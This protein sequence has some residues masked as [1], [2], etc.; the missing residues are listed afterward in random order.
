MIKT[1]NIN[2]AG[3]IF[4][5]NEDAYEQLLSY[6][7]SLEKFYVNEEGK[8]EILNDIKARF[9][10]LF[11]AKGKNIIISMEDAN[12][13]INN[14]G[15]PEEFDVSEDST[16]TTAEQNTTTQTEFASTSTSKRLF[17]DNDNAL[18]AGVCSGLSYYFGIND[19]VWL[20]LAFIIFV[21]IGFGSPF[22]IYLILW[23]ILPEATTSA[24]KLEMKG[25]KI[26]L[27]NIEKKV[28]DEFNKVSD[29]VSKN[30][31]GVLSK[32]VNFIGKFVLLF[33][34]FILGLGAVLAALIGGATVL[35]LFIGALVIAFISIFGIPLAN[36]FFFE[37]SSDGWM[38]GIGILLICI[39]PVI[40]GVVTLIHVLSKKTK[41]L[42]KQLVFPLIGLFLFGFLLINI[43][44]YHAKQ[45]IAE[46]RKIN[47][48]FSIQN[49]DNLDT[50]QLTIN[51][52][53]LD[54]EHSGDNIEINGISD[55]IE[56][57][58]DHNENIYP[59]EIEIYPSI[60]DSFSIVREY[61][62]NGRNTQEALD[63]AV[64]FNHQMTQVNNRIVIDPF[65]E[66][67]KNN[68][69]FRNQ[70]LKI[71]VFVPEGKIIRWDNNT[72][73]YIDLD[74]IS[75]NWDYVKHPMPPAPPAPPVIPN[76]KIQIQKDSTKIIINVEGNKN[77]EEELDRAQEKLDHA[78]EKIQEAHERFSDEQDDH[79]D[80]IEDEIN[81]NLSK[82]HYIFRMVN[83]ELI[84]ID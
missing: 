7:N 65:I 8:D 68:I 77:I 39:I 36:R 70:K 82:Q 74:M 21:I 13:A 12:A 57:V 29:N 28:K 31:N 61:S 24:Q 51:P 78:R 18:V 25:E 45:L 26:N 83:G 27:S 20:R 67:N 14:M 10:E 56:L 48:S 76:A 72:E 42:R 33:I 22:L 46:K 47:Q 40:L 9:A 55:I 38:F 81:I 37:S 73:K 49:A 41:P 71:K 69:K 79:F 30:S 43:S 75:F 53:L 44:G 19:P 64:S 3:Q 11:L 23:I 62:A 5:I 59:V 35:G 6:F 66:F 58:A 80:S 16:N 50:L 52:A 17:R 1:F 54:H 63:N 15:K 60:N 4:N 34:K 2:L 32:I 84:P